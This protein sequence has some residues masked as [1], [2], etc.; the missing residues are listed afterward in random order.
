MLGAGLRSGTLHGMSRLGDV[1]RR[2]N[3]SKATASR[4]LNGLGPAHRISPQTIQA[5]EEA[6]LAVRYSTSTTPTLRRPLRRPSRTLGVL[7]SADA[8]IGVGAEYTTGILSG[9]FRGAHTAGYHVLL[10]H[11][12]RQWEAFGIDLI[13]GHRVDALIAY[14]W[15]LTPNFTVIDLDQIDMPMVVIGEPPRATCRPAVVLDY[16][17]AMHDLFER[18]TALGHRRIGWIGRDEPEKLQN[19]SMSSSSRLRAVQ[20]HAQAGG[21]ELVVLQMGGIAT[22]TKQCSRDE[23]LAVCL[24]ELR[25][26][27]TALDGCTALLCYNDLIGIAALR[28]LH[29][30]GEDVPRDRSVVG[31]DDFLADIAIPPLATISH[32]HRDLGAR[33]AE[34]AVA[35]AADPAEVDRLAGQRIPITARFLPAATL[36]PPRP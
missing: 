20:A 10:A 6:A 26:R 32:R 35:L 29:E 33:A 31:F 28:V 34:I 16:Q 12:Q 17:E 11:G 4:V 2:A 3:V 27:I 13:A 8:F 25:Q 24:S 14:A 1:A 15:V 30:R 23:F 19:D 5:V 7:S 36:G 22:L 18:L 21:Q 9:L